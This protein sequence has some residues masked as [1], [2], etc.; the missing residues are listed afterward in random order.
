MAALTIRDHHPAAA[1][2]HPAIL[3]V[4]GAIM[5]ALGR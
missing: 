4:P 1:P 2:G 3:A 5:I